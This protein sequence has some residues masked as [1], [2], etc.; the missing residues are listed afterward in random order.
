MSNNLHI[1][2]LLVKGVKEDN[3][4]SFKALFDTYSASLFAFSF[5]YLKSTEMAEDVVQEVFEKV[6]NNRRQLRANTSFQAY[7]FTIA[8]NTIRKHFNKLAREKEVEYDIFKEF[9]ALKNLDDR[10]DFE[11]LEQMLYSLI[12]EMPAKRKQVF[13]LRKLEGKSLKEIASELNVTSKTVEYHITEAMKFLRK[14]F[15]KQGVK[16][17]VFFHIFV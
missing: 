8:L 7:L 14:E 15:E 3:H 16:G 9:T 13:E 4:T 11:E 10:N 6:W 12:D 17:I 5:S 2:S 1:E